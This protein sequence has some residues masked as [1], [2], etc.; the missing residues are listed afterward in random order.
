MISVIV[1]LYNKEYSIL[2][3]IDSILSQ[4]ILPKKIVIVDDGSTDNSFR[5]VNDEYRNNSIVEIYS[6]KNEGVSSARNYG[7]KFIQTE[8]VSFLDADDEWCPGFISEIS[9]VI[10][11]TGANVI[12]TSHEVYCNGKFHKKIMASFHGKITKVD[13][14]FYHASKISLMNSSKVVVQKQLLTDIDGFPEGVTVGEDLYVWARL[15]EKNSLFFINDVLVRVYRDDDLSRVSRSGNTSY[16]L[17]YYSN[18]SKH[19]R[20][21]NSSKYFF[22]VFIKHY[23]SS[24]ISSDNEASYA[25]LEVGTILFGNWVNVLKYIPRRV[26]MFVF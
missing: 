7:L 6:K 26:L 25:Y 24:V 15:M 20:P 3:A 13:D 10:T 14:Y 17:K 21:K 18:I 1:P 19:L 9:K 12:S 16:L 11:N 4:E 23:I 5:I 8:Y 2:R 22:I